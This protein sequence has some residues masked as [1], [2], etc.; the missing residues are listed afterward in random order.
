MA[1]ALKELSAALA[2]T[3][4]TEK[5]YAAVQI[6]PDQVF[7]AAKCSTKNHFGSLN[8]RPSVSFNF[9]VIY[10]KNLQATHTSKF[11][12]HMQYFF[13]DAPMKKKN[14]KILCTRV[15][16]TFWTPSTK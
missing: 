15:Y 5:S 10:S 2:L 13:A 16:S 1:G 12:D 11:F 8:F 6:V 4:G 3:T 7:L 9:L 14:S